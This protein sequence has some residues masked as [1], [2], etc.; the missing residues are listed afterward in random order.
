MLFDYLGYIMGM[1]EDIQPDCYQ[2]VRKMFNENHITLIEQYESKTLHFKEMNSHLINKLKEFLLELMQVHSHDN[3]K[4][5]LLKEQDKVLSHYQLEEVSKKCV[6]DW[7][8]D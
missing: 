7:I 4:I 2:S 3:S 8:I 5:A 6:F 1:K